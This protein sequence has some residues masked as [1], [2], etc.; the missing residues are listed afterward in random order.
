[1]AG[2]YTIKLP[3]ED[4]HMHSKAE[5]LDD[6]AVLLAGHVTEK[7]IFKDITTGATNDL[8]QATKLARK[9]VT[10]YGMSETLGPRTF[11]Q[12]EELIFLGREITEQRDYSE[13]VA[14]MIDDEVSGFIKNAYETAR[15]II[16]KFRP[17]LEEV[18]AILIKKES[19]EREEFEA[20]FKPK[21]A[22]V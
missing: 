14:Q 5:F 9:L 16:K 11:G 15:K 12:K 13:K 3:I 18:V 19:I 7:E 10:E 2:G 1:M 22:R 8:K 20:L 17:K 4:K 21:A 6:L